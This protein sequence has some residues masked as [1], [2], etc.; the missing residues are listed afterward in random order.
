MKPTDIKTL[1]TSGTIIIAVA[2]YL[3]FSPDPKDKEEE[4]NIPQTQQEENTTLET[5][6]ANISAQY[7][8]EVTGNQLQPVKFLSINDGDT[9]SIEMNGEKRKVRLLMVDTP[10][11]N[12]D[13]GQPMPYAE[14]AKAFT[15]NLLK[16]ASKIELLFDVGPETD[17]YDRLL[18]YIYIDDVLLQESLLKN[19]LAV[20]RYMNKPN[21]TLEAELNEIQAEAKEEQLHIWAHEGYF[22][23]KQFHEDVVK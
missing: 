5:Q 3:I 4:T 21:N 20:M 11:M 23:G 1:I 13:T 17:K 7:V 12:Y 19:G 16:N 10:E 15:E 8:Q 6:S 9:F 22:D 14:D 2:L 18:A